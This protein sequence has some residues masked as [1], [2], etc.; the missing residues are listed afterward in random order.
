MLYGQPVQSIMNGLRQVR[1]RKVS[2][3]L[4]QLAFRFNAKVVFSRHHAKVVL[5]VPRGVAP[6]PMDEASPLN[7]TTP[8]MCV[9]TLKRNLN[10]IA[11]RYP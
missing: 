6:H 3:C 5:I 9:L 7:K 11:H 10:G 1:Q 2:C 8:N 4:H